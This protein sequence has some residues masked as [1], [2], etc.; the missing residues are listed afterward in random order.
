LAAAEA[1][2]ASAGIRSV[3]SAAATVA[4]WQARVEAAEAK[5]AQA[6]AE[7]EAAAG[8]RTADEER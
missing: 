8:E 1:Q 5:L 3:E 7:A 6:S 4:M 2:L